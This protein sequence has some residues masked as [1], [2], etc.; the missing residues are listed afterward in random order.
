MLEIDASEDCYQYS[1]VNT[2]LSS[3]IQIDFRSNIRRRIIKHFGTHPKQSLLKHHKHVHIIC[4]SP[5]QNHSQYQQITKTQLI[6]HAI[7]S[8]MSIFRHQKNFLYPP[9]TNVQYQ[10]C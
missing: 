4:L 9:E 1:L 3:A 10:H 6:K 7:T 8:S 2:G 5:S